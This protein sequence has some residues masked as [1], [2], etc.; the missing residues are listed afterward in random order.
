MR[1]P[2]FPLVNDIVGEFIHFVTF[3]A[4]NGNLSSNNSTCSGDPFTIWISASF[5]YSLHCFVM[6]KKTNKTKTRW[7]DNFSKIKSDVIEIGILYVCSLWMSHLQR[8]ICWLLHETAS[9]THWQLSCDLSYVRRSH[10]LARLKHVAASNL[11]VRP[12]HDEFWDY[13]KKIVLHVWPRS[14]G[15]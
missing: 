9:H 5:A 8:S 4:K 2:G 3:I 13:P 11:H 10:L 7:C 15:C 12:N 1:F 14:H 6:A